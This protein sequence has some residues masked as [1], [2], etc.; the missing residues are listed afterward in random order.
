MNG[1]LANVIDFLK[2]DVAEVQKD[3]VLSD[4]HAN[5]SEANKYDATLSELWI[6]WRKRAEKEKKLLKQ[7]TSTEAPSTLASL[8]I[9]GD[10]S[11]MKRVD[12]VTD[13]WSQ[14]VSSS[15]SEGSSSLP[16]GKSPPR[17]DFKSRV[18][19]VW[20]EFRAIQPKPVKHE[21]FQRYEDEKSYAYSFWSLLRAS[22]LYHSSYRR[23]VLLHWA[24]AGEE[25][26]YLKARKWPLLRV[27]IPRIYNIL[28]VDG[29][30]TLRLLEGMQAE[31]DEDD[32][33]A[34][35]LDDDD[36]DE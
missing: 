18:N 22:Y 1:E 8:L 13:L 14:Q 4:F 35:D 24:L 9:D 7:S 20:E 5:N 29:K 33:M 11:L 28:K 2:F 3:K 32:N 27:V 21:L 19:F 34:L 23:G 36:D 25:L 10:E 12:A 26:C 15:F 30:L 16:F 17:T 31:H 6:K